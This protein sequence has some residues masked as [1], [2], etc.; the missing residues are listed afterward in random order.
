MLAES[1]YDEPEDECNKR[2]PLSPPEKSHTMAGTLDGSAFLDHSMMSKDETVDEW[3]L[4][5]DFS[6]ETHFNRK[7]TGSYEGDV[8]TSVIDLTFH[9]KNSTD[10]MVRH[11]QKVITF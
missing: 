6:P 3:E 10:N 11:Q 2:Y 7:S 4:G 1:F 5:N 9:V 8:E